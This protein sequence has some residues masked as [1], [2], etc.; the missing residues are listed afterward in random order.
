MNFNE[1][2]LLQPADYELTFDQLRESILVQ[3]PGV[4]IE[5]QWDTDWRGHLVGQAEILVRLSRVNYLVRF[6]DN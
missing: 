6:D 1:H 4:D 5:P 3:G 2:G